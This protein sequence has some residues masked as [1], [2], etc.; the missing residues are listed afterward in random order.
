[1]DSV[2]DNYLVLPLHTKVSLA[3]VDRICALINSGW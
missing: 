3:D 2:D 1:M